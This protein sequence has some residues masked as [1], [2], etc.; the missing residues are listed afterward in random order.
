MGNVVVGVANLTL[1]PKGEIRIVMITTSWLSI[2]S[3]YE[4]ILVSGCGCNHV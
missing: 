3:L 2:L 4:I 1:G